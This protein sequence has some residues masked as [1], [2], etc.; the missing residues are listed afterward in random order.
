MRWTPIDILTLRFTGQTTFRAP[1]PDEIWDKR[2]TALA[3]VAQT[4]AFKAIDSTGNLILTQKK[5]LLTT[6]VS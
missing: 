3:Y 1:N 5:R 2:S 4:G 6:S